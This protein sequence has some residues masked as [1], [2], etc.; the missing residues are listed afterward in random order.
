MTREYQTLLGDGRA[1]VDVEYDICGEPYDFDID[2]VAIKYCKVDI[3]E[4][5]E[6]SQIIEIEGEI[7]RHH[8]DLMS[9]QADI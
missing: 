4:C 8:N 6:H 7:Y 9:G 3:L 5:L 2:V 1:V